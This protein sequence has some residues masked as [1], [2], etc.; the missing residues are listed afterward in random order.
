MDK[1]K[2][3]ELIERLNNTPN[4]KRETF[5]EW[6][7]VRL[8]YDRSPFEAA[9]ALSALLEEVERLEKPLLILASIHT[10][11]DSVTGYVVEMSPPPWPVAPFSRAE[12]IEA[13]GA[14][15]NHVHLQTEPK[16]S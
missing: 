4:W 11:E 3:R 12:Y 7:S 9:E 13:W 16:G 2:I 6:K 5:E 1:G 14:V 15:R 10:R 8:V